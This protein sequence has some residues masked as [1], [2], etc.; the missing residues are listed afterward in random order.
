MLGSEGEPSLQGFCY[1]KR[2]FLKLFSHKKPWRFGTPLLPSKH[3]D[4]N[5][6][7]TPTQHSILF[8]E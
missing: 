1:A 6:K 8:K 7:P 3:A 5:F 4:I 2:A